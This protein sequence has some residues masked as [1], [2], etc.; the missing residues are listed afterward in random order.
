[1]VWQYR[2]VLFETGWAGQHFHHER[3]NGEVSFSAI[4]GYSLWLG[5]FFHVFL[6]LFIFLFFI[7]YVSTKG[8]LDDFSPPI[9]SFKGKTCPEPNHIKWFSINNHRSSFWKFSRYNLYKRF[10]LSLSFLVRIYLV[11][12]ASRFRTHWKTVYRVVFMEIHKLF[13]FSMEKDQEPTASK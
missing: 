9:P 1:M 3:P 4:V 2:T 11:C 5:M 8:L 7:F 6:F 12:V 13:M 10:S